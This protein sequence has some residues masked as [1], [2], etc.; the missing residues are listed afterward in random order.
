MRLLFVTLH[1]HVCMFLCTHVYIA[2]SSLPKRSCPIAEWNAARGRFYE[3][4]VRGS[5]WTRIQLKRA[6]LGL[7]AVA[8]FF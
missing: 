2:R 4:D 6:C 3:R 7:T 1:Y 5:A 8:G